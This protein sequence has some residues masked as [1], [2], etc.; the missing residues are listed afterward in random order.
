MF[1]QKKQQFKSAS[2]Q[3]WQVKSTVFF[4]VTLDEILKVEVYCTGFP[5]TPYSLLNN[6]GA[7]LDDDN[8]RQLFETLR[9]IK[10][11]SP[12]VAWQTCRLCKSR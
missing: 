3:Q 9:R 4:L 6:H 7:L 12:K 10:K 8:A 2:R 5:C 1:D 11:H